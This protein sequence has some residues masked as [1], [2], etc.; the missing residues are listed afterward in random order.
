MSS[1]PS[2]DQSP[3]VLTIRR[4]DG[5]AFRVT[6]RVAQPGAP[7]VLVVPAMGLG[8]RYYLR[9]LDA[10]AEAGCTGAVTELRGHEEGGQPAGRPPRGRDFGY[11][12]LVDDLDL[13]L[14]ALAAHLPQAPLHLLGHSLGGQVAALLAAR[15]PE[16]LAGL[17]LVA[18]GTPYWRHWSPRMLVMT[19]TVG[20]ISRVLG[21]FPGERFR[22]AGREARTQ[23]V[24]W[25]RLART[26]RF[27]YGTPRRDHG[28]AMASTSLPVLAVSLEGD[29]LAPRGSVDDLAGRF[30]PACVE[31]VHLDPEAQ[32][33]PEADHLR[34]ARQPGLVLPVLTGWLTRAGAPTPP[35]TPPPPPAG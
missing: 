13:A 11:A 8:S 34:W 6:V 23:M 33:F 1:E 16:R 26:G 27:L 19:Q 24:D 25:A 18:A 7:A 4:S 29:S 32:G 3:G 5:S 12:E 15:A 20:V 28:A 14:A 31:R 9:L 35:A 17:V 2:A 21:H 22:F 10:L 30:P